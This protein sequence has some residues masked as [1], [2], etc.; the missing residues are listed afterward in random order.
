MANRERKKDKQRLQN[1]HVKLK[2][3][4]NMFGGTFRIINPHV[5]IYASHC[6]IEFRFK[7]VDT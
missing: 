5:T 7:Y 1:T 6:A 4:S 2:M 3:S